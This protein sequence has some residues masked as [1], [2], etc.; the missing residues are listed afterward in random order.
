MSPAGPNSQLFD[1]IVAKE[2]RPYLTPAVLE[3]T[4]VR[5]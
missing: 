4:S 3:D 1:F 5:L 2:L